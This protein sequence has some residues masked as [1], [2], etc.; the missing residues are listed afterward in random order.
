M[1]R[2]ECRNINYFYK[3]R[4]ATSMEDISSKK[5]Y[6]SKRLDII[7]LIRFFEILLLCKGEWYEKMESVFLNCCFMFGYHSL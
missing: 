2:D 1:T 7:F 3:K 6:R 5:L 4:T